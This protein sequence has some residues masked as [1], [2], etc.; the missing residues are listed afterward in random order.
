MNSLACA[1]YN[2]IILCL[3]FDFV[4]FGRKMRNILNTDVGHSI[5]ANAARKNTLETSL[6]NS[7]SVSLQRLGAS[8][9]FLQSSN[10]SLTCTQLQ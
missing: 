8:L 9:L 3:R 6:V 2:G 10:G 5:A 1:K 4:N 7:S